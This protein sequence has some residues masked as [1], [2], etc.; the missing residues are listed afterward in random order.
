MVYRFSTDTIIAD[1]GVTSS[2]VTLTIGS[3][4]SIGLSPYLIDSCINDL[5]VDITTFF[6]TSFSTSHE[7]PAGGKIEIVFADGS[8]TGDFLAGTG[9]KCL[10]SSH[11]NSD[12]SCV[13]TSNTATIGV[14][15][16][17]VAAAS[18]TIITRNELSGS[19]FSITSITSTTGTENIDQASNTGVTFSYT[20]E[21][22]QKVDSF[23]V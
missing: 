19:S 13:T 4:S 10:V 11:Q 1:Y 12:I 18:W 20:S 22:T 8:P 2:P 9:D 3:I 14:S 16:N 15:N 7:V 21:T 23:L 5:D 6:S 17:A